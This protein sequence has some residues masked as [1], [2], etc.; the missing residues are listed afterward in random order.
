MPNINKK[1]IVLGVAECQEHKTEVGLIIVKY[2]STAGRGHNSYMLAIYGCKSPNIVPQLA[3]FFRLLKPLLF[4][5]WKNYVLGSQNLKDGVAD[6]RD[7]EGE[8][9]V[10][11][12]S[13]FLQ[14]LEVAAGC[15]EAEGNEQTV[16]GTDGLAKMGVLER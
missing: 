9:V 7:D 16:A 1:K 15:E 12:S 8:C 11:N 4:R 13:C 14:E 5:C 6:L 3:K 2:C 10:G